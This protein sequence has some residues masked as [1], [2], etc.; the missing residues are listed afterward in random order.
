[1]P[2]LRCWIAREIVRVKT[3]YKP[4]TTCSLVH[5]RPSFNAS[6]ANM[7]NP[8]MSSSQIDHAKVVSELFQDIITHTSYEKLKGISDQNAELR[9]KV[10]KLTTTLEVNLES[11]HN[12]KAK[13]DKSCQDL[14]KKD[15]QVKSLQKEADHL[16][17]ILTAKT[18]ELK[19]GAQNTTRAEDAFKRAELEIEDLTKS[20]EEERK[21]TEDREAIEQELEMTRRDLDHYRQELRKLENFS[22]PLKPTRV[23]EM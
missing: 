10:K 18:H 16:G 21:K 17:S 4:I 9:D 11:L 22:M 3:P 20:L 14:L 6:R 2:L 1:M 13:L 5:S 12:T 15:E 23:E 7:P 19:E 8:N